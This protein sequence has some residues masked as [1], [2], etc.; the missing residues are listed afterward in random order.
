MVWLMLCLVAVGLLGVLSGVPG[1]D[2]VLGVFAGCST[3]QHALF[4]MPTGV[5]DVPDGV[6]GVLARGSDG[7]TDV[8]DAVPDGVLGVP[9]VPDGLPAVLAGVPGVL[10]G[11]LGLPGGAPGLPGGFAGVPDV[12]LIVSL[13]S[14]MLCA[15]CA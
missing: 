13:L 2:G 6:I 11:V 5:A 14:L 9:A 7:V 12:C 15:W 10:G 4:C 8:P 1:P 3:V